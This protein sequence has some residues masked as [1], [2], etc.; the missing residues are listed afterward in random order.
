MHVCTFHAATGGFHLEVEEKGRVFSVGQRQ[1]VCLARALL[2]RSKVIC[3]DEAT[4]NVD[5]QTDDNIQ[6][7]ISEEFREST[8]IT[9]AH[10]YIIFTCTYNRIQQH[11]LAQKYWKIST[12]MYLSN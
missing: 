7:T 10:R 1:L 9:I 4:A 3:I 11:K 2:K 12:D 5:L 8:V 6:S